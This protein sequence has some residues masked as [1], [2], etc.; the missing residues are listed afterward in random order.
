MIAT[1]RFI[2]RQFFLSV[3]RTEIIFKEYLAEEEQGPAPHKLTVSAL[4][5]LDQLQQ[6]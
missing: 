4:Q 5:V 1:I 2:T 6:P 3:K